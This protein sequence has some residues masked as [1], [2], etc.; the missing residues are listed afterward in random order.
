MALARYYFPLTEAAAVSPAIS[1]AW[2]HQNVLRR[3]LL[4]TPDSSTLTTVDY[5]PDGS[6]HLVNA[7]SHHRQYVSDPLTVQ[8]IPA[9]TMRLQLQ[10][11]EN[12]S[13]NNLFLTW[14]VFIVSNDGA[15]RKEQLV[16]AG[17]SPSTDL[18]RDGT[19]VATS[20]T[21]RGD[22]ATS[23]AATTEEGDRLV[24]EIGLGG[25]PAAASGVQ[26]HN[27]DIR[28]GCNASG[29]DLPSN[30]TETGTTFRG[31]LELPA[32]SLEFVDES[33]RPVRTRIEC[34]V[35]PNPA[36]LVW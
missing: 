6:D 21:N 14:G 27:G 10:C 18:K 13:A 30:D 35:E 8:T 17:G 22:T 16:P 2:E 11:I 32:G 4:R 28:W 24:I 1:G 9:Q 20:L 31:Y 15:T 23:A 3:R 29:G 36:D 25:T 19:E 7:D 12:H 26:G 34:P 33:R 5:S